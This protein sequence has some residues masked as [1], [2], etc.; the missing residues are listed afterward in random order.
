MPITVHVTVSITA[1]KDAA[2]ISVDQEPVDLSLLGD[3]DDITWELVN[4][5]SWTFMAAGVVI[6]NPGNKFQDKGGSGS[7]KKHGWTRKS[8]DHR[9]YRYTCN[10]TDGTSVLS[11][12][13][14]IVN[15]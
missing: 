3:Q 12:D 13:P 5:P 15:H 4:S 6:K 2:S 14:S 11:W 10:V 7:G 9:T 8:R 1:N